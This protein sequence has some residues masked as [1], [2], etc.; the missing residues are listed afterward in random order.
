MKLMNPKFLTN[1]A[2]SDAFAKYK[3]EP[4]H[5]SYAELC[6]AELAK[7]MM[8]QPTPDSEFPDVSEIDARI[9][10]EHI[11][12]FVHVL[13]DCG[14]YGLRELKTDKAVTS[15]A[16]N[17]DMIDYTVTITYKASISASNPIVADT[18][19]VEFTR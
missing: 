3:D 2:L 5:R 14:K 12:S 7:R 17:G 16:Q 8:A 1:D 19:P 18:E 13:G 15:M 4:R 9:V 10:R 6:D 11:E